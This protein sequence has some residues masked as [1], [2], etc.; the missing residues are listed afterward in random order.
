[1]WRDNFSVAWFLLNL[2]TLAKWGRQKRMQT[3]E[4]LSEEINKREYGGATG[5]DSMSTGSE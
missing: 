4:W 2:V 3:L 5:I 1:M